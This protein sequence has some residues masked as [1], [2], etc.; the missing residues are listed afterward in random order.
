MV[1]IMTREYRLYKP[2]GFSD[3]V[4]RVLGLSRKYAVGGTV[5]ATVSSDV[6][7]KISKLV[8]KENLEN[9]QNYS[10]MFRDFVE[11]AKKVKDAKFRIY[12]VT[13]DRSDERVTVDGVMFPQKYLALAREI[14]LENALGA[15]DEKRKVN[16]NI[17]W[18]WD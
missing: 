9:R 14:L 10:P 16:S 11:F 18:W 2:K 13:K 6:L 7:I 1:N 17:V 8:P 4:L 3:K 12:V 5:D 15:P